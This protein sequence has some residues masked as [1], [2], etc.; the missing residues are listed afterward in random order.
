MKNEYAVVGKKTEDLSSE[1]DKVEI[2]PFDKNAAL[3]LLNNDK[4]ALV[5]AGLSAIE[6]PLTKMAKHAVMLGLR[7]AAAKLLNQTYS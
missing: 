5:A 4:N 3:Q 1:S 2:V 6:E 7:Y